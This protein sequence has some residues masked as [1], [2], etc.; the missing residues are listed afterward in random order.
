MKLF[1]ALSLCRERMQKCGFDEASAQ[2]RQLLLGVLGLT[3]SDYVLS[4]RREL[5]AAQE[6]A[7]LSAL[8]RRLSGV[9]LQY[10]LGHWEFFGRE[11]AC[12]ARALIPRED[13]EPLVEMV[14]S[15]LPDDPLR[16]IDLGCGTGIIGITLALEKKAWQVTCLDISADALALTGEN[17][18]RLS[19]QVETV[20][21][22]MRVP[23]PGAPY[24]AIVSNPPYIEEGDR[25]TLAR[26]LD[27]EPDLALFGGADGLDFY[28]ALAQRMQDSLAPHGLIAVEV[29]QGQAQAVAALFA[30]MAQEIFVEKDFAGIDRVVAAVKK[31]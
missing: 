20:Q 8:N 26:E 17:A 16:V 2:S 4:T 12:D 29:G 7:L 28:R 13:T 5:T 18:G 31:G 15:K 14:L 24:D 30:P 22:D 11:F 23:L 27:F 25:E 1:E 21:G 19:A 9:P 3:P 10:V 6:D